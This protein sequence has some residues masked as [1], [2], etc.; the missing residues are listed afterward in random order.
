MP[1]TAVVE[2]EVSQDTVADSEPEAPPILEV[3]EAEKP[4]E[5]LPEA[6]A[7]QPEVKPETPEPDVIESLP[8]EVVEE[9]LRRKAEKSPYLQE[10]LRRQ[11][12]SAADK[13]AA[14]QQQRQAQQEDANRIL[15]AGQRAIGEIDA[16]MAEAAK[17]D[18]TGQLDKGR[19]LNA[20]NTYRDAWVMG[21]AQ[22]W[23]REI[24]EAFLGQ[25][26]LVGALAE[27][28][29]ERL[30]TALKAS[31]RQNT[32]TP[33]IK[34][35][36]A[37]ACEKSLQQGYA[38]AV[39]DLQ[40]YGKRQK[41]VDGKKDALRKLKGAVPPEAS[42]GTTVVASTDEARLDRVVAGNPTKEDKE[43]YQTRY[44]KYAG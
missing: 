11:A 25:E 17:D 36:F 18:G 39:Q 35:M 3:V 15:Q 34:E 23:N 28:D 1:E 2:P 12:Q 22:T 14:D 9:I 5:T 40:E 30:G 27:P 20:I 38:L 37:L 4:P 10:L 26:G 29:V 43:W 19:L 7:E 32:R 33:L 44:G 16:V 24:Q 41:A 6:V 42:P 8:D 13:L 21:Q 31:N